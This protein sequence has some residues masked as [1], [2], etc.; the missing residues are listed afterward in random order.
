MQNFC[1]GKKELSCPLLEDS[2]KKDLLLSTLEW[3]FSL[4]VSSSSLQYSSSKW[5][6]GQNKKCGNSVFLVLDEMGKLDGGMIEFDD[7]KVFTPI[8]SRLLQDQIRFSLFSKIHSSPHTQSEFWKHYKSLIISSILKTAQ[9]NGLRIGLK[10]FWMSPGMNWEDENL[11]RMKTNH[12][13]IEIQL[14]IDPIAK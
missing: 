1:L 5:R 10:W 2:L 3:N 12:I 13:G 6:K 14:D 9:N 8:L 11:V 7:H 4:A